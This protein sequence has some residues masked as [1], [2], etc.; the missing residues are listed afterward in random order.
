MGILQRVLHRGAR[1]IGLPEFMDAVRATCKPRFPLARG[2]NHRNVAIAVSGGLDS[3]A[4]AFLCSQIRKHD[5]DFKIA[6]HPVSGFRG[7]VIDHKLREG[8]QNEGLAVCEALRDMG[9]TASLLQLDWS[10]MLGDYSHPK[11]LPNFESLARTL[12]YQKLGSNCTNRNI[13]SLLTAHHEDDQYETV[14]MRLLQ[15]HGSRG[16]RG[17]RKATDIPECKG[18]HRVG[19]SGFVDDQLRKHPY[20]NMK[21]TKKQLKRWNRELRSSIR[22]L[23]SEAI[24]NEDEDDLTDV[25]LEEFYQQERVSPPPEPSIEVEDGGVTVYRPLLEFSKDRLIATCVENNIPWWEDATNEDPTLT[26]RN[27]VRHLYKGYTLPKAL[28][29]PAIL[30]LSKKC[31]RKVQAQEDEASRLLSRTIIHD[32]EPLAGTVTVQF[33]DLAP[34]PSDRDSHSP[35]RRQKRLEN[36]RAVAAVLMRKILMLVTPESQPP[37]LVT[38]RNHV[39]RLFPSLAASDEAALASPPRAFNLSGVHLVPVPSTSNSKST[40]PTPPPPPPPPPT[41]PISKS[42]PTSQPPT[43]TWFLSRAPYPSTLPPPYIRTRH[44]Q[45]GSKRSYWSRRRRLTTPRMP[46][47]LWDGRYWVHAEHRFSGRLVFSPYSE[48]HAHAFRER[49]APRDRARLAR[50]LKR[51]APGK[52]RYTLP[53]IYLEEP[54]GSVG[55]GHGREAFPLDMNSTAT[56]AEGR[57]G[58]EQKGEGKED[59]EEDKEDKGAVGKGAGGESLKVPNKDLEKSKSESELSKMILLALPTLDIQIP[60]ANGWMGYEIRYRKVDR[61]TLDTAGTF[62]RSPFMAPRAAA[63]RRV[64]VRGGNRGG[65]VKRRVAY[66]GLGEAGRERDARRGSEMIN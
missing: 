9:F 35:M 14:L 1:P 32:F 22:Y 21:P 24:S 38:L 55:L 6:D 29:K 59:K 63:M 23:A 62:S 57:A 58:G 42:A 30:A 65:V 41:S 45:P 66:I 26:M 10:G 39:A 19:Q 64:H 5:F 2:T 20:Y 34:R 51:R 7:L 12:R 18:I 25:D 36:R 4:L 56:A 8:S 61:D 16:L 31:E 46:W 49:L 48:D 43:T 60:R 3:M 47:A 37:L 52:V 13:A 15:G 40:T 44:W 28:Q 50:A 33:P 17:M 53:G 27:A 54:P 11:D